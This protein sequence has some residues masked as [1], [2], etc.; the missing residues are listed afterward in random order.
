MLLQRADELNAG[1]A[2]LRYQIA[3]HQIELEQPERAL[4]TSVGGWRG[5]IAYDLGTNSTT[6]ARSTTP[7]GTSMG[8]MKREASR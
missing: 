5:S 4:E 1:D 7:T 8:W 3:A 6:I 2:D